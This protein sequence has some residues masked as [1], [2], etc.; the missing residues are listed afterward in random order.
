MLST[1]KLQKI[2]IKK[3]LC[4]LD[5]RLLYLTKSSS[6]II[7]SAILISIYIN[8]MKGGKFTASYIFVCRVIVRS[9]QFIIQIE[10]SV[11]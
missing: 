8:Y 7:I 4:T 1:T 11:C 3:T 2:K 5:N 6:Y 9:L 10:S